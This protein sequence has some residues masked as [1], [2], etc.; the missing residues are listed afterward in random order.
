MRVVMKS[1]ISG[2]RNGLSWPAPGTEVDL[3]DAEAKALLRSGDAIDPSDEDGVY[4]AKGGVILTDEQLGGAPAARDITEGQP[5]TNLARANVVAQKGSAA[6]ATVREAAKRVGLDDVE[7]DDEP[8]VGLGDNTGPVESA[9][10][11][12]EPKRRS[13]KSA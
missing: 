1:Q 9:A 4:I 11:T 10:L 5:D 2:T 13:S 6:R 8:K 12:N 3:P 7:E